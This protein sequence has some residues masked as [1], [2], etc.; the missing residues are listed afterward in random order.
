MATLKKYNLKAEEVGEI[1][2]SDSLFH[3]MAH[4]Q[5]IKD[6]L[7]ALRNNRRQWSASTKTRT[8][9][10]H[11]TRKC[12]PQ[13]GS[14]NARHGTDV[15]PQYRGGGR[16]HGP[17]PKFDQ[18]V[19]INRQE[20]RAAIQSLL[21]EKLITDALMVI[22]DTEMQ[23]PKTKLISDFMDKTGLCGHNTLFIAPSLTSSSSKDQKEDIASDVSKQVIN[24]RRS[25][26]NI[27]EASFQFAGIING[28]DL[29]RATYLVVSESAMA[30]LENWLGYEL[31]LE[32]V[33]E[34]V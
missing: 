23:A 8:E 30:E 17:R 27:P 32:E 12:G 26:K 5:L 13:K 10:A 16:A 19:R 2:V 7:V 3:A 22:Q 28:Y 15:A 14:G 11:T 21:A 29:A 18:H 31:S 6:Y 34:G 4:D 1:T 25:I 24:F 33:E 9:V 20:K